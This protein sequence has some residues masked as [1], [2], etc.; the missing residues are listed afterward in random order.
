MKALVLTAPSKLNWKDVP[1]LKPLA[2][3]A[4]LRI[5]A[6]GICGSDLHGWDGSS[7]R[8]NPPLIMGHEA[9]GEIVAVGQEERDGRS[10]IE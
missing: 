2:D 7:G 1:D 4:L 10:A 6:C 3:E 8:R 9:A 5:R